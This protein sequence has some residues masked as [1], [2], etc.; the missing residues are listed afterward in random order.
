MISP[1]PPAI[2]IGDNTSNSGPKIGD[3]KPN[4]MPM[5]IPPGRFEFD[6]SFV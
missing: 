6:L 2:Y 1:I 5:M 4:K 3:K